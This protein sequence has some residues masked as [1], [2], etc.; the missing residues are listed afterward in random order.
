[1]RYLKTLFSHDIFFLSS[2][3]QWVPREVHSPRQ[4]GCGSC[5]SPSRDHNAAEE[6][7]EP[8]SWICS[9]SPGMG[10]SCALPKALCGAAKPGS[11]DSPS[12]NVT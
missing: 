11:F 2:V 8:P 3:L 7:W 6:P 10:Q 4:D 1:M 12:A 5:G 9:G